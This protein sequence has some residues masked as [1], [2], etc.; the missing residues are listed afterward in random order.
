M[1]IR[2]KRD[3]ILDVVVAAFG[4]PHDMMAFQIWFIAS[5]NKRSIV[6]TKIAATLR[7]SLRQL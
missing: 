1:T 7:K 2:T 3:G 4:Q 6:A 5:S